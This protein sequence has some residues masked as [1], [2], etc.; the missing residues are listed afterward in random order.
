MKFSVSII[1]FFSL[2]SLSLCEKILFLFPIASKSHKNVFDPLIMALAA[3]GHELTVVTPFASKDLP[4]NIKELIP[5][6]ALNIILPQFED[7]FEM[8]KSGKL[9]SVFVN[10]DGILE[11]CHKVYQ[12]A[13]FQEALAQNYDLVI[14]N[15]FANNCFDGAAHKVGAPHVIITTFAAPSFITEYTGNQLPSSFVPNPMFAVT[16]RMTFLQRLTNWLGNQL[17]KILLRFYYRSKYET[18]YRQYVGQDAPGSPEILGNVSLLLMNSHFSLTY[19]RPNFPDNV[20]VGGM[21]CRPA[22]PLPKVNDSRII[23]RF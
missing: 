19:P 20:E 6:P 8:R 12:N 3:R 11:G 14:Q 17:V 16:D 23:V 5:L 1:F 13:E 22:Q 9:T 4:K 10:M 18:I 15:G 21:H 7:P 2:L